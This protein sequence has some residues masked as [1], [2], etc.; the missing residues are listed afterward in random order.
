MRWSINKHQFKQLC[1]S[2]DFLLNENPSLERVSNNALHVLRPHPEIIRRYKNIFEDWS[3]NFLLHFRNIAHV[4]WT[5]SC[6]LVLSKSL[7][8]N[9]L[10]NRSSVLIISHLINKEHLNDSNDF[11][12]SDLT[13]CLAKAGISSSI[14][15][16]NHID[17]GRKERDGYLI[18]EQ[19]N[20]FILSK[21]LDFKSELCIVWCLLKDSL[22]LLDLATNTQSYF[23]KRVFRLAAIEAFSGPSKVAFRLGLQIRAL[24][25]AVQPSVLLITYEGHAWERLVFANARSV[26]PNIVCI[27]YQHSVLF[28]MQH[29][30]KRA[31]RPEYNPD[32]IF[33]SGIS[34]KQ[35]LKIWLDKFGTPIGLLGSPR[36]MNSG[37][38]ITSDKKASSC[39]VIPEAFTGE[40]NI[41]FDFS[42]ICALKHPEIKFI[43][44]LHPSSRSSLLVGRFG[45]FKDLPKNVVFSDKSIQEDAREARW[46]LYRGS[47]AII[48][49]CR[50]CVVPIYVACDDE[51]TINS[52]EPVQ[53]N[54]MMASNV[55][56]FTD[57]IKQG[58]GSLSDM[59]VVQDYCMKIFTEFDSRE[60]IQKISKIASLHPKGHL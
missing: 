47:T 29:A 56:D 59:S 10:K 46:A 27:G 33:T 2:C 36:Y 48:Q 19:K 49:V 7:D 24:V 42:L 18:G 37:P 45:R 22:R 21:Y 40:I 3:F 23:E 52:L 39:L 13:D 5:L 1:S 4:F 53:D 43:W 11:Y 35:N 58:S 41:L 25:E 54:V 26:S 20:R 14:A 12:F 51:I 6:S 38:V 8:K 17:E 16:I 34:G 44:R 60:F 50:E 9:V 15:L 28:Y 30:L 31:L 55:K 32:M 57:I